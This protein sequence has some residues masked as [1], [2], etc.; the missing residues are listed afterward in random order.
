MSTVMVTLK[1]GQSKAEWEKVKQQVV[2]QGGKITHESKLITSFTAEFPKDKV[3][4]LESNDHVSVEADQEV[5][6]Q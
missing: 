4:T 2:D 6:T 3:H 1:E 5:K